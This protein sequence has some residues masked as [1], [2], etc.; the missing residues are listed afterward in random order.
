MPAAA[1]SDSLGTTV[2]SATLRI[3][4]P[5]TL[6]AQPVPH[7]R[8]HLERE[9]DRVQLALSHE[10]ATVGRHLSW[11]LLAQGL[12]LNAYLIVLVLGWSAPL[13]GKRWLLTAL[14]LFAVAVAVLVHIAQRGSQQAL[15]ALRGTRQDLEG[16]LHREF[17]RRPVFTPTGRTARGAAS[18][19]LLAAA[20]IVGWAML[21][22]YTLG[23]PMNP[24]QAARANGPAAAP[25]A[26]PAVSAATAPVR[27]AAS[28]APPRPDATEPAVE[29]T[30]TS[31]APPRRAGFKW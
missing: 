8:E 25:A 14:A 5:A 12:L 15:V 10:Q 30:A 20:F 29:A 19:A 23:A 22:L 24:A 11:Q 31:E 3:D 26:A 27:R 1:S 28:P 4:A 9:L 7:R 13:P 21:S 2:P 6:P 18:A 16:A 17:G